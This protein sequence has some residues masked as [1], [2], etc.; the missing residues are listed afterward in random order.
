MA[1]KKSS[2]ALPS[3]QLTC[4]IWRCWLGWAGAVLSDAGIRAIA[5]EDNPEA[6]KQYFS[7]QFPH[8][9]FV[10]KTPTDDERIGAVQQV[11]DYP[12]R[13]HTLPLDKSG[14]AFQQEVWDTLPTIPPGTTSTYQALADQLGKPKSVRAVAN[15]CGKNPW[16][17]AIPCHRVIGSNGTLT[18]YRWGVERKQA[19]LEREAALPEPQQLSIF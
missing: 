14:T 7:Q 11:I 17:I 13:P 4:S 16:A 9:Q 2:A 8:A 6:L 1:T 12:D 18:G 10:D 19:L 3:E 15:A 5:L